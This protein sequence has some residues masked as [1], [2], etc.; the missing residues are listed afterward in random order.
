M[1]PNPNVDRPP[2][3]EGCMGIH[4]HVYRGINTCINLAYHGHL[5]AWETFPRGFFIH[6]I[7]LL[8]FRML[9]VGSAQGL[10]LRWV[11]RSWIDPACLEGSISNA[12]E[13]EVGKAT[14]VRGNSC[15][16]CVIS[17]YGFTL[18]PLWFLSWRYV[19]IL[20]FI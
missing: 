11:V 7:S 10:W 6:L 1:V 16:T 5:C 3:D 20:N 17:R 14:S 12:L 4:S 15:G 18:S 9:R 13:R 2:L 19:F 8:V